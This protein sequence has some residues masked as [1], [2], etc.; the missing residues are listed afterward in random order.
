MRIGMKQLTTIMAM[1][2]AMLSGS[3]KADVLT[4]GS[5]EGGASNWKFGIGGTSV[6]V[7]ASWVGKWATSQS[8][9]DQ[10]MD[11]ADAS[12]VAYGSVTG[13]DGSLSALS[14]HTATLSF[15]QIVDVSSLGNV[16]NATY[17]LTTYAAGVGSSLANDASLAFYGFNDFAGVTADLKGLTADTTFTAGATLI[18]TK[19]KS[20]GDGIFSSIGL[21]ESKGVIAED[22]NYLAV[23]VSSLAGV[24]D[25]DSNYI[26][27]DNTSLEV[28]VI[29]EPATLGMVVAFGAG[30]LFIRRRFML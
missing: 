25:D 21:S 14:Q 18:S 3:V 23:V 13:Q 30:I 16:S 15:V 4:D 24:K 12:Q 27:F 9:E 29:P 22:Y 17:Q 6:A 19:S 28:T 2:I 10:N 5:F 1:V 7:D 20:A 8:N 11:L 26:A